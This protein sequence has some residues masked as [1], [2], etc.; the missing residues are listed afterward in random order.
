MSTLAPPELKTTLQIPVPLERVIVQ[1]E[2]APVIVTVPVGLVDPPVTV[3]VTLTDCPTSD[4][5]GV[6]AVMVVMVAT[7]G[8]VTAID[9]LTRIVREL[10]A[11]IFL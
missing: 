2:S 1:L 11:V 6:S 4:G 9:T 10:V 3:T 5:S 7:D 8:L